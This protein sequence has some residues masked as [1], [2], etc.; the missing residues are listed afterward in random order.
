VRCAASLFAVLAVAGCGGGHVA[1]A[2]RRAP[3]AAAIIRGWADALRAGRV[4]RAGSY[5]AL[6]VIVSNGTPP[7]SVETRAQLRAFHQALPC[8]ARLLS[9]VPH[10]GYVIAEFRLVD[11]SGAGAISPCP[12][13]GRTAATAFRIA[14]GK[15]REWR[16]VP[17]F[18]GEGEPTPGSRT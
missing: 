5:F 9:T 4:Q 3:T 11:R 16:R 12:G 13:K 18:P 7:V 8:G 15:I 2:T 10:H 1:A 14:K 17:A 6:P